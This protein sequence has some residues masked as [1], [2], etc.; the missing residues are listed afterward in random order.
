MRHVLAF[1]FL[2]SA[3]MAM[4]QGQHTFTNA[5][6]QIANARITGYDAK[7]GKIQIEAWVNPQEPQKPQPLNVAQNA[8]PFLDPLIF[9]VSVYKEPSDDLAVWTAWPSETSKDRQSRLQRYKMRIENTSETDFVGLRVEYCAYYN[10]ILNGVEGTSS[11]TE[12]KQ[13]GKFSHGAVIQDFFLGSA[14]S[15]QAPSA[16]FSSVSAGICVRIYMPMAD[17]TEVVREIRFPESLSEEKYPWKDPEVRN[18][19]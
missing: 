16:S 17:G 6:G 3:G 7:T 9:K 12:I 18:P 8:K 14:T 15:V 11:S 10:K 4:G 19:S 13:L 1:L 2:A 5:T